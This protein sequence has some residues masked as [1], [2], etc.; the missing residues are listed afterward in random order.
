MIVEP[1]IQW[2][3]SMI[4]FFLVLTVIDAL[5]IACRKS[6]Y[7]I[8]YAAAIIV[9]AVLSIIDIYILTYSDLQGAP[10]LIALIK[11]VVTVFIAYGRINKSMIYTMLISDFPVSLAA[12]C[13]TN[14]FVISS[15]QNNCISKALIFLID[16]AAIIIIKLAEKKRR[17]GNIKAV[18]S[19]IPIHIYIFILVIFACLNGIT[20]LNDNFLFEISSELGYFLNIL[21]LILGLLITAV[22]FSLIF[23]VMTGQAFKNTNNMLE[24]QVEAQ[25]LLYEQFERSNNEMRRFRHDYTNHMTSILSLIKTKEYAEAEKYIEKLLNA[26][27]KAESIFATGNK[28]ADAILTS[29][30]EA[31]NDNIKIDYQGVIPPSLKNTDLCVILSNSL[32]NATEACLKCGRP[33]VISVMAA[34][35][36]GYF[37]LTVKNP[38]IN[39]ETFYEIPKTTKADS[40]NHGIGLL[41]IR[42]TARNN[43]GTFS[44]KCENFVFELSVT[45]KMDN[46]N[47]EKKA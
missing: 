22:I 35:S 8:R 24:K 38:T 29:K 19:I 43:D 9:F 15:P 1:I 17:T 4:Y 30:S 20:S 25:L 47:D 33:C 21:M 5:K 36:H 39:P 14:M 46:V 28:V 44:V 7:K 10:L 23:N 13:I 18:L 3:A 34:V 45:M 37:V 42:D 31:L 41:N 11:L 40:E 2:F 27:T 6:N 26:K 16:T 32:D 12:S